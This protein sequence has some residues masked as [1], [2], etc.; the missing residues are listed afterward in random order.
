MLTTIDKIHKIKIIYYGYRESV[1]YDYANTFKRFQ[2]YSV[3]IK[4]RYQGFGGNLIFDTNNSVFNSIPYS[5]SNIKK[6]FN[7]IE[8]DMQ[9][10]KRLFFSNFR[11]NT[12]GNRQNIDKIYK[13]NYNKNPMGITQNNPFM[14]GFNQV[15]LQWDNEY[16]NSNEIIEYYDTYPSKYGFLS[17][18]GYIY[19]K[20]IN[21]PLT[22][23]TNNFFYLCI[24]NL[25]SDVIV[26]QNNPIGNY[27]IFGKVYQGDIFNEYK[28]KSYDVIYD[29]KLRSRLE[30][31]ELFLLDKDGNLVNLNN[32]DYNLELEIE[33]YIDKIKNINTK[34]G[35]VF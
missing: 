22:T 23:S 8:L 5:I 34:N 24:K 13:K 4:G 1:D 10:Q 19:K 7:M 6:E 14:T 18:T 9:N 31:L 17:N 32:L 30:E 33:E 26:D 25:D 2:Y 28:F 15:P 16:T 27:I 29:I 21:Q 12:T 35:M 11:F 3:T 20:T